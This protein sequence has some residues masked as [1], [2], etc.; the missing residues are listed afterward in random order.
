VVVDSPLRSGED[1]RPAFDG[2]IT[3][4]AM[5]PDKLAAWYLEKHPDWR[6][7]RAQR[8]ALVMTGTAANVFVEL[9]A[10]SLA[11]DGADRIAELTGITTPLLLVHGDVETG[12]LVHPDDIVAFQQ[13]LPNASVARIPKA[14]HALHRERMAEFLDHAVPFLRKHSRH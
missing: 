5:S 2:W 14:G 9:K 1:F 3:Q 4:N 13:R 11:H 12:S 6:E 8:R 10:D 7:E